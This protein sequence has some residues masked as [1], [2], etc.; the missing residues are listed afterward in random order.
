GMGVVPGVAVSGVIDMVTYKPKSGFA[1]SQRPLSLTGSWQYMPSG[2]DQGFVG[3]Y[4]TKWNTSMNMRDTIAMAT[5]NLTSMMMSWTSFTINL[6]Y[7]STASPD[8]AIIIFSASGSTPVNNSAMYIDNLA[9]SGTATGIKENTV[10]H[11]NFTI[12]PNP[13]NEKVVLNYTLKSTENVVI[14]ISD[15]TGKIV[16]ELKPNG[17][18]GNNKQELNTSNLSQGIYTITIQ[19]D[20][21]LSSQKLIVE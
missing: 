16:K 17:V 4:L 1:Y 6:N 3:V 21:S 20:N 7:M 8:S 14:K 2:S 18:I 15:V 12:F 13:S 10:N 5:Q 19:G 11:I 9:F